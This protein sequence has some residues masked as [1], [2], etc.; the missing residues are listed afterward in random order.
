MNPFFAVRPEGSVF[1]G[2]FWHLRRSGVVCWVDAVEGSRFR[3]H[4]VHE[5]YLQGE[6]GRPQLNWVH[7]KIETEHTSVSGIL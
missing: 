3:Q 2:K 4:S 1:Q 6:E 5:L 7:G